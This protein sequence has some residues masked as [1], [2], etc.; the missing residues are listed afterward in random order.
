[1]TLTSG[2]TVLAEGE[3]YVL[4]EAADAYQIWLASD[5]PTQRRKRTPDDEFVH[6]EIGFKAARRAFALL[7]P[8]AAE[9]EGDPWVEDERSS[10]GSKESASTKCAGCAADLGPEQTFCAV[11]GMPVRIIRRQVMVTTRFELAGYHIVKELGVVT[12]TTV[13]ARNLGSK[14]IAGV[15]QNFGG[16][17][18]GYT[19]LLADARQEA[20]ERMCSEASDAGANAIVSA[21]FNTG[22]LFEIR[23]R[24][25][26]LRH[27]SGC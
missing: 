4:V 1:M 25:S 7:E 23:C 22:E 17:L 27:G 2:E 13:R 20:F 15:T 16:E 21:S 14:L 8:G 3:L 24:A 18:G 26:R 9:T 6:N 12:G 19:R 10:L 5:Y 11:C